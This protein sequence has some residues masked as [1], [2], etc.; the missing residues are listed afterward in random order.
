MSLYPFLPHE[1]VRSRGE[2]E[3]GRDETVRVKEW[4]G[5]HDGVRGEKKN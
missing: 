1:Y 3:K 4:E 2:E 5:E